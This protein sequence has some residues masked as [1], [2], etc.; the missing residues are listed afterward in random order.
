[1]GPRPCDLASDPMGQ[2]GLWCGLGGAV[3][4]VGAWRRGPQTWSRWA[5]AGQRWHF[6]PA[7]RRREWSVGA[8]L[9]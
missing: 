9:Q 1:M 3:G 7:A 6:R 4:G 5:E 2:E 8:G